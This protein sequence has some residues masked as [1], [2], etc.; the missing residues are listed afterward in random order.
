MYFHCQTDLV[1]RFRGLFPDCF[2]FEGNRAIVFLADDVVPRQEL[3]L[4]IAMA[5]TYHLDKKSL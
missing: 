1:G 2:R 3:S 4:C 5:L